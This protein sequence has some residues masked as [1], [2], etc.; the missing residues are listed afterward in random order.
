MMVVN[1]DELSYYFLS[2]LVMMYSIEHVISAHERC[3]ENV[4]KH[5]LV[6]KT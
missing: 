1:Y 6:T 4:F 5:I 2:R 3:R